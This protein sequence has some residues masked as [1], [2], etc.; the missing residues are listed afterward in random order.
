MSDLI[1]A[2]GSEIKAMGDG[3]VSGYLVRFTSAE[4]PDLHGDYF[5]KTTDFDI[6]DGDRASIYYNHGLDRTLKRR[7]LGSGTLRMDDVGIWIDAQ[8]RNA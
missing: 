2:F 5:T 4:Q 7:K 8:L 3:K 1:L 6:A